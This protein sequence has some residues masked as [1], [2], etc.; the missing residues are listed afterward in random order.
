MA[1]SEGLGQNSQENTAKKVGCFINRVVGS[2][3]CGE[4]FEGSV[5]L[6]RK[7]FYGGKIEDLCPNSNN[8]QRVK[9]Q[10]WR[11]G[12]YV[13]IVLHPKRVIYAMKP[14]IIS[15]QSI[16]IEDSKKGL[17]PCHFKS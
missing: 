17:L 2:D 16:T 1:V 5:E 7:S 10:H 9:G 11:E 13:S 6:L 4:I 15:S 12:L 14:P 3:Y 8:D